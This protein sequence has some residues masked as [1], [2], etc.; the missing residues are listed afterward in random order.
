MAESFIL[1]KASV[2]CYRL[3]DVA[4]EIA[5]ERAEALL[6]EDTRRL[7]FTREGSQYLQ[8]PNPP[9]TVELGKRTLAMRS[10]PTAVDA[11][12]R[13]FD[14][15]AISIILKVPVEPGTSI[16]QLVPVADE[17]HDSTAVENTCLQIV[18]AL[19]R[20]IGPVAVG[21]HLWEQNES[22]TVV[23][24]EE[25]D[26]HPSGAEVLDRANLA[27]L[28][29]GEVGLRPLS[30]RQSNE[31]TKHHFSYTVDDLAVVDWNSAF[32]YEP[33]G[34]SDIPDII[35]ICNAQLLELRYYD[36][37]LDRELQYTYDQMQQRRRQWYSIFRSPYK[38]LARRVSARLIEI[39]EFI[40]RVE[41]SLK[42]IG[43]FYLAKLYDE[44]VRRL[45]IPRWQATVTRKQALLASVYDM[46][47][48]EVDTDRS[49][50][51]EFTV[52]VLIVG[53]VL[54]A[55]LSIFWHR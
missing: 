45:R 2:W 48:G 19:R 26:G 23:F 30:Q 34:S 43:D 50:T 44:T 5:L 53:E 40:E 25:I 27:Q 52:V 6:S 4:Q 29:L 13:I 54:L 55:I 36:D 17:L 3:F 47:K 32:V 10:G 22:Y 8:L 49:F 1:R 41:N 9:L 18:E 35:E 15:G 51:L 11:L 39:S 12:A 20:A 38:D 46:L 28:L 31:V 33:S 42:I 37:L 21:A 16:I 7:R 24:A 14:H